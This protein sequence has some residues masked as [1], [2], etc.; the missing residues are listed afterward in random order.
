MKPQLINLV[1]KIAQFNSILSA[2]S[3]VEKMTLNSTTPHDVNLAA[4]NRQ[5]W[6]ICTCQRRSG[7]DGLPN[8]PFK[9]KSNLSIKM[10]HSSSML[11]VCVNIKIPSR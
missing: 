10:S 7:V 4:K 5:L 2:D 11:G 3:A 1:A 6:T 9:M 8:F